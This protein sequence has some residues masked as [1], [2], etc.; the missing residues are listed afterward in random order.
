[1]KPNNKLIRIL[2]AEFKWDKRRIDCFVKILLAMI[3]VR[4]VNL[5]I[6]ATQIT[7]KALP[8]NRYRRLQ[9]FFSKMQ[10]NYDVVANFIFRLFDFDNKKVYL[11]MDRTNWQWGKKH[12]NVL[13]ICIVYR[14]I[15]IPI[16]W[17]VL[18]RAG[19]SKTSERKQLMRKFIRAIG[20]EHI[21]G[22]LADREFIG[23]IWFKWLI[24]QQIPFFIRIRN[25]ANTTNKN[26]LGIDVSWLF[27]H[28]KAGE[29]LQLD[30]PKPIFGLKLF[31]TGARAP[32]SGEFMIIVSNL[33]TD[34]AIENYLMRWQIETF[35]Q[36]LKSRGF[37]FEDTHMTDPDK[38]SKLIAIL[39]IAFCWAYKAGEWRHGYERKIKLK[40]HGRK[41]ISYFRHGLNLIHDAISQIIFTIKPFYKIIRLLL[42]P[43]PALH[44]PDKLITIGARF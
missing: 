44:H 15:G 12:I 43:P 37:N 10:I 28:L 7:S 1:M 24:K 33:S 6:I 25:D 13:L 22:L 2:K 34:K 9:R 38:I 16:Y 18:N 40:K 26:G 35:F 4:T 11:S 8:H 5:S 14:G 21:A 30:K 19:N 29:K 23:K 41:E 42:K 3:V 17:M 32:G 31:L 20:K 36:C 27:Y 39:A